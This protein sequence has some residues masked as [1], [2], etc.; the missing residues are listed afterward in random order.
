MLTVEF[1]S[2]HNAPAPRSDHGQCQ[3]LQSHV[4]LCSDACHPAPHACSR[5]E[6][7]H[8]SATYHNHAR[9]ALTARP[10]VA[11]SLTT[12][13]V[14]H[15][16][17][18]VTPFG[19]QPR[20]H[21]R[22]ALLQ[23]LQTRQLSL[24]EDGDDLLLELTQPLPD[25]PPTSPRPPSD[26]RRSSL[27]S[28]P[29]LRP[30]KRLQLIRSRPRP[31]P[32]SGGR[33][34][35]S[36]ATPPNSGHST[37]SDVDSNGEPHV[38][39]QPLFTGEPVFSPAS[40]TTMSRSTSPQLDAGASCT[41]DNSGL[42]DIELGTDDD[43]RRID[44][45]LALGNTCGGPPGR[46]EEAPSAVY[47][48]L[49]PTVN[50]RPIPDSGRSHTASTVDLT[51]RLAVVSRSTVA[52]RSGTARWAPASP[53]TEAGDSGTCDL[54]AAAAA[55]RASAKHAAPFGRLS[56]VRDIGGSSSRLS[57]GMHGGLAAGYEGA[58]DGGYESECDSGFS[59][60]PVEEP[61][62]RYASRGSILDSIP[63]SGDTR[64]AQLQAQLDR[65]GARNPVY[66]RFKLCWRST[67]RVGSAPPPSP[68][69]RPCRT[70][71]HMR[72]QGIRRDPAPP[73]LRT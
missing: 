24:A 8:Q 33:T 73:L 72:T 65:V 67:R 36:S 6:R 43:T 54:G 35:A 28:A 27:T 18:G 21:P 42:S 29:P 46:G 44:Q 70:R 2:V 22:S 16:A 57:D 64:L 41:P 51:A 7:S 61:A 4:G 40:R 11:S 56:V 20:Q 53:H 13:T 62:A 19:A 68:H 49:N 34:D 48:T 15:C 58:Y 71:A 59:E 66:D 39:R 12:G 30:P 31:R 32:A 63:S 60:G 38:P 55:Q 1:H 47:I 10:N 37:R 3:S 17:R 69:P 9:H 26:R 5:G 14:T 52:S 23:P 25:I 50:S 45:E